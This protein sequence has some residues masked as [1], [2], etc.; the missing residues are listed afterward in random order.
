MWVGC[1]GLSQ[2]ELEYIQIE[3]QRKEAFA[4]ALLHNPTDP[5]NAARAVEPYDSHRA[6]EI[7]IKWP[8]D[9]YVQ[10]HQSKLLTDVTQL[11]PSKV[12]LSHIAMKIAQDPY[13]SADSK[14]KA[15]RYVSDLQGWTGN[16]ASIHAS[17]SASN[18]VSSTNRVMEVPFTVTLD[19]WEEGAIKQQEI[20]TTTYSRVPEHEK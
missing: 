1:D 7:S 5:L 16:S 9:P 12:Q 17:I 6:F 8:N 15:V 10:A 18:T 11:L 13:S 14:L 3:K 19:A 2:Q 20:L 4:V